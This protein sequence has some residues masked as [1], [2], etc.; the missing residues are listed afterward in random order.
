MS[1]RTIEP[2]SEH[3]VNRDV[4]AYAFAK[5]IKG[6][7]GLMRVFNDEFLT[8]DEA[9]AMADRIKEY[10]RWLRTASPDEITKGSVSYL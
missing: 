2:T 8:P 10:A 3:S 1:D 4:R 5:A 7:V 9:D 6:G